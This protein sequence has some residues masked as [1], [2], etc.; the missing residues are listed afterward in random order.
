MR[1]LDPTLRNHTAGRAARSMR[2]LPPGNAHNVP[3]AEASGRRPG[4]QMHRFRLGVQTPI[5][6]QGSGGRVTHEVREGGL[7]P[8]RDYP[9]D[10]KSSASAIPPLSRGHRRAIRAPT[11]VE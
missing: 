11:H 8:P 2:R 1:I 5:L 10:P 9:L 3:I 4:G 6:L 7:E